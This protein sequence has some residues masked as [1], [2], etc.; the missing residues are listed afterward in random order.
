MLGPFILGIILMI[1]FV[2]WEIYGTNYPMVPP[3]LGKD[4]R[5]LGLTL[6]ITFLSGA[7]FFAL[8]FFWPTEA[9]NVY[10]INY[11]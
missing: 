1:L 8:L 4:K 10:G 9:Y 11:P 5:I 6:I 2:L 3:R 7:N